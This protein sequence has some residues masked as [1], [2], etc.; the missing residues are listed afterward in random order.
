M[1]QNIHPSSSTRARVSVHLIAQKSTAASVG[2]HKD[3][4]ATEKNSMASAM[5]AEQCVVEV[6]GN[7]PS[8]SGTNIPIRIDNVKAWK[9]GLQ[10]S[11]AATPVKS[12][13]TFE[14]FGSE[15]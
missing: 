8:V 7:E 13:S 11:V 5:R 12:L 6:N 3:G 10:L 4:T 2:A 15:S 14:D 9:A 1:N